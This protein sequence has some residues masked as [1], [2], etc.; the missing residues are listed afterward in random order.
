MRVTPRAS[1]NRLTRDGDVLKAAVTAPPAEG[2][3]ND[4]LIQ[5]I[6]SELRIPKSTIRIVRGQ[7]SRYKTLT[8]RGI[9]AE[10]LEKRIRHQLD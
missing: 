3:A 1:E 9:S 7:K 6:S 10:E 5:L 2:A 4:A 8:V